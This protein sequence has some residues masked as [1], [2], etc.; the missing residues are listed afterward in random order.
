MAA[1]GTALHLLELLLQGLDGGVSALE[2]FVE[3]V[4][5][6]DELLLPLPEPVLLDLDLLGEPLPQAL[7]LLL[8]FGVVECPRPGLAE[9]PGLHLRGA[10]GLVVLFFG[11]VDQVKHVCPDED[12]TQLLE[13]AVILV[14][15]FGNTPRVLAALD[16]AAV[17]G[18]DVLL[19]ANDSEG[20]GCHQA[21]RVLGSGLV[22]LLDG[23]CVDL[24]S[25]SLDDSPDL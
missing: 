21:A 7:L 24:N 20:H 25:L 11:R 6:A 18:L 14:L 2:V 17:T 5:L 3:A 10:V 16:N 13:V 23:W 15:N 4:A 19:G 22:I 9:F 12:G 1:D 8:E